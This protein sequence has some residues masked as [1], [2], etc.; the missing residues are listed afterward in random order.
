MYMYPAVYKR[1]TVKVFK[2][3]GLTQASIADCI[4]ETFSAIRTVSSQLI[5]LFTILPLYDIK[6]TNCHIS[7]RPKKVNF[8]LNLKLTLFFGACR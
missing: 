3:Y 6:F 8:N 4:T 7:L 5:F 2:A 1:S